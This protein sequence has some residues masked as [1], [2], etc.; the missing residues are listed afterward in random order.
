M[1]ANQEFISINVTIRWQLTVSCHS[2]KRRFSVI[3]R[4]ATQYFGPGNCAQRCDAALV[5]GPEGTSGRSGIT[6]LPY[7]RPHD[8]SHRPFFI[9][10]R[11]QQTFFVPTSLF[12]RS[13][14]SILLALVRGHHNSYFY[15]FFSCC[16]VVVIHFVW[17]RVDQHTYVSPMTSSSFFFVD[18]LIINFY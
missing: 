3:E 2:P 10:F 18:H 16:S 1:I 6:V 17:F 14:F 9:N 11:G 4:A 5:S 7:S 13:I 15:G 8:Y 12:S